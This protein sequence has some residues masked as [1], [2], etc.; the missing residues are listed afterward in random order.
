MI[1][2]FGNNVKK[3]NYNNSNANNKFNL[4]KASHVA[5]YQRKTNFRK[6]AT[7]IQKYKVL[8]AKLI[9]ANILVLISTKFINQNQS[10]SDDD[11][12]Y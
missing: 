5:V 4:Q 9:P 10:K 3:V 6:E 8:I 2:E 12:F 11:F 1:I 7:K